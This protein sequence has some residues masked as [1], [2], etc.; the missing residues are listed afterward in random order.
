MGE[1][2][3]CLQWD[4]QRPYRPWFYTQK[5]WDIKIYD[6]LIM[7]MIKSAS[8]NLVNV[9]VRFN[10]LLHLYKW[11]CCS[12]PHVQYGH[13][14]SH[15]PSQ[16]FRKHIFFSFHLRCFTNE[17]LWCFSPYPVTT[18]I[19]WPTSNRILHSLIFKR[20]QIKR[21]ADNVRALFF[22]IDKLEQRTWR[23]ENLSFNQ[24]FSQVGQ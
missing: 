14:P 1:S 18:T 7:V 13:P 22:L 10:Q 3:F 9:L 20:M 15:L 23:K 16:L 24:V 12:F 4:V 19:I 21:I 17:N 2:L 11:Y 8:I 5:R 6:Q